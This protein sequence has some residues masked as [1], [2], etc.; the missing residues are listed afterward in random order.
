MIVKNDK[1]APVPL[2][3][4]V[5]THLFRAGVSCLFGPGLTEI[6]NMDVLARSF[7]IYDRDFVYGLCG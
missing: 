3:S 4:L 5:R 2:V 1:I 6:A 7:D